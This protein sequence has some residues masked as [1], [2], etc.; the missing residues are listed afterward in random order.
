MLEIEMKFRLTDRAAV[1]SRLQALGAR[2]VCER[3]ETDCYYNA[4]DRDFGT[5]DEVF[6][7]RTVGMSSVLTY[8]G[9]KRTGAV[10]TRVEIEVP[11]ADS[12]SDS[13]DRMIR[14][15]GYRPTMIV[16]KRRA[17]FDLNRN[18]F[19]LHVC[20]DTLESI[21]EFIELEIVA[22]EREV[23]RA[24]ETVLSLARELGL[25]HH[26]PRAY[27]RMILEARGTDR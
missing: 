24:E 21:G 12:N 16:A 14:A 9:P 8:K 17:M 20:I 13:A 19:E 22:D 10:K 15:L 27:L 4:P 3:D 5:T 2:P 23:P 25:T 18:G 11:L 7:L 26:E 6:R 1:Q